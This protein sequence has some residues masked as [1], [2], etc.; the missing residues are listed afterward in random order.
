MKRST[1]SSRSTY[2]ILT[3]AGE[4]KIS[5]YYIKHLKVD[6]PW[7]FLDFAYYS[8]LSGRPIISQQF[9]NKPF[10]KGSHINNTFLKGGFYFFK[11]RL[12]R[13]PFTTLLAEMISLTSLIS[14]FVDVVSIY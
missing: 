1:K 6:T 3:V 10:Q 4:F 9:T 2:I 8:I 13:K 14:V 11:V 12:K 7:Y 5:L